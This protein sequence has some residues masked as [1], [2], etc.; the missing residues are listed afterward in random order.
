MNTE[1]LLIHLT[2]FNNFNLNLNVSSSLLINSTVSNNYYIDSIDKFDNFN[3]Y[4]L[5][6]IIIII[7]YIFRSTEKNCK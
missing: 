7:L 3:Q 2:F 6:F 1:I 5:I 4:N